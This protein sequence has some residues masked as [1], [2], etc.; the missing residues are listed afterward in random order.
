MAKVAEGNWGWRKEKKRRLG[1]EQEDW[2][3]S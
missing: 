1:R 2:L 3:P